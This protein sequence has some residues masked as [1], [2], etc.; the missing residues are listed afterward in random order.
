MALYTETCTVIKTYAGL[1]EIFDMKVV[2]SSR[3]ST[4]P[5]AICCCHGRF[6][7]SEARSS[8]PSELVYADYL[9]RMA[10]TIEQ[11]G[12]HVAEWRA[13][14][15]DKGLKVDAGKS[16]MIVNSGKLK[17]ENG[18]CGKGVQANSGQCTVCLKCVHS[19]EVVYV[20]TCRW[21]QT[22][23]PTSGGA[24]TADSNCCAVLCRNLPPQAMGARFTVFC[25]SWP[26]G[27]AGWMP[28]LLIK[29]LHHRACR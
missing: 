26:C 21:L 27:P 12:R 24:V 23:Q 5:T 11:L 10:P 29:S 4:E 9:I 6:V 19:G 17:I 1:S 18:V 7:S 8:L 28:L 16:K 3:V 25:A 15:L 2:F 13:I 20:M 22:T 14:L